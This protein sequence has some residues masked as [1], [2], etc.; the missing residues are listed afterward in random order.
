MPQGS[1]DELADREEPGISVR[2]IDD[3][4]RRAAELF[5]RQR[6]FEAH[7]FLE[8]I[9]KA[10][11]IDEDDRAFWKAVTQVAVGC[12]HCQRRNAPGAVAL[13]ERAS[14]QLSGYPSA[15][16]G[17]DTE[18]LVALAR[19]VAAAVAE[20]GASPDLDFPRFPLAR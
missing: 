1:P 13:L 8:F 4:L 6:F 20:H 16:R 3:A 2:S 9:W 17:I 10:A 5:D 18:S 19:R 12:C 7:E 14:N 15:H 11:E